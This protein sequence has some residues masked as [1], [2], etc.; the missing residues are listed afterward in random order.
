[1]FVEVAVA[2]VIA[3]FSALTAPYNVSELRICSKISFCDIFAGLYSGA[4]STYAPNGTAIDSELV[5]GFGF[6]AGI[7]HAA[8]VAVLP[9]E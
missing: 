1:M 8:N 4:G 6:R 9:C 3:A 5:A 2:L 7:T